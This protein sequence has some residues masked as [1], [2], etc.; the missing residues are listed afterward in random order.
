LAAASQAT[1]IL[2]QRAGDHREGPPIAALGATVRCVWR[3]RLRPGP[4]PILVVPDGNI[5]L[6]WTGRSMIIAG[7]DSG[8]MIE[9]MPGG[10][11]VLGVRLRRGSA[12]A[13]LG[14]AAS[15]IADRRV[16]LDAVWGGAAAAMAERLAA[17]ADDRGRLTLLQALLLPRAPEVGPECR[18]ALAILQALS[19]ASG[20][21]EGRIGRAASGLALSER[22]LRRHCEALFGL[23]PR[24]LDRIL[25]F[26]RALR[27]LRSGGT[28]LAELAGR[29]GYADQ[30]HLSR[31][32]RRMAGLTPR[33]L[34]RQLA[35]ES[36]AGGRA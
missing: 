3:N 30:A 8:P 20:S 13:W 18:R 33:R 31:E 29:C 17:A 15:A 21:G 26:Q 11:T 1:P 28:P 7:P 14:L 6:V 4:R 16:P 22:S 32:V 2:A 27:G 25:R 9:A 12:A 10:T 19:Q 23:G 36:P 5:D 24:T 34:A 35:G